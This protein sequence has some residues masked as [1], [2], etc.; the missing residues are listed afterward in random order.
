MSSSGNDSTPEREAEKAKPNLPPIPDEVR[1]ASLDKKNTPAPGEGEKQAE[2]SPPVIEYTI[3]G[4]DGEEYGPTSKEELARW[5]R[6]DKANH[7]TLVRTNP[8]STWKAIAKVPELANL[9]ENRPKKPGKL[10]AIAVMTL[11]GGIVAVLIGFAEGVAG[12]FCLACIPGSFI[13]FFGGIFAIIQGA[14]LLRQNPG[15]HLQRT[16]ITAS[17]QIACILA[18]DVTN[19]ILGILNHVFLSD[20]AV[21][22]Y[23]RRTAGN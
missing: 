12:T 6:A 17:I 9:L 2:P 7:L 11:V 16:R 19:L 20:E 13:S 4:G 15:R 3:I 1:E 23:R 5:I 14:L 8:E 10:T 18:G 22:A 21:V